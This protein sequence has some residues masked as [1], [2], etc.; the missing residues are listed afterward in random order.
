MSK[1]EERAA[2]RDFEEAI[3][4]CKEALKYCPEL[5]GKLQSRIDLYEKRQAHLAANPEA[6]VET[7]LPNQKNQEYQIQV[8]MEQGRQLVAAGEYTRALRKFDNV[9]LIDPYNADAIQ[10]IKAT[11]WR[12][13]KA[14]LARYANEHRKLIAETEWKFAIPVVPESNSADAVNMLGVEPKVKEER[15][16][17]ALQ[18]KLDSIRIPRID[19]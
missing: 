15:E 5:K 16:V 10:N 11:Y 13:D 17:S 1:A 9:L 14:G 3:R 6:R 2:L 18:K 12:I 19:F 7:L 8:L 4:I